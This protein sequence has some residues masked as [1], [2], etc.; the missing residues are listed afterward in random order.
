MAAVEAG[1]P[2]KRAAKDFGIPPVSLRGHLMGTSR[3]RKRGKKP[4]MTDE[5]EAALVRYVEDMCNYA[6]P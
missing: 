3:S 4:V 6:H 1:R 5:E 2:V